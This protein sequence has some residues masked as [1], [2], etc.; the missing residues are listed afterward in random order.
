MVMPDK[1][2]LILKITDKLT[3]K[4][5]KVPPGRYLFGSPFYEFPRWQDEFPHMVTLTKP[6]YMAET[7]ITQQMFEDVMGVN[8][9][10]RVPGTW[11]KVGERG[12]RE[13]FRHKVPDTGPDFAVENCT[14]QEI[15]DF[16]KKVS[17]R[18]GGM[19]VRLPTQAEWSWAARVGTSVP[20]FTEKYV[21]QRSYCGD[22]YG[23]CEPV[24]KHPPNA[25]GIYDMVRSGREWLSD[26][27]LDNVRYDEIDPKGPTRAQAANHHS[28]PLRR[29]SS[30]DR[31]GDTHLALHGAIDE[32]G[33]CEEGIAMFR[34][35]A[36]V[37]P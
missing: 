27:K 29:T 12:W 23:R 14:W 30:G 9:S 34:L 16:C 10:K 19:V 6:Y 33:N 20:V 7:L 1:E 18:N 37:G 21:E 32:N 4:C 15:Q 31:G 24:K 3:M 2:P 35:V 36:E 13:Q 25:W 8:P 26:Y 28:G 11:T 5:I 22:R 17:E